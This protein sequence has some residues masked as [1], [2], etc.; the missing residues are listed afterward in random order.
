MT[1]PRPK[2]TTQAATGIPGLDHILGGG[3][4]RHWLYLV[5]GAPGTGKTTLGLQFLLEG[6][7]Q[8]ERV[9]YVTLS[10]TELELRE[11]AGSHGWSMGGVPI[12]EFSAGEA[13]NRLAADQTVLHTA[14]V[15]LGETTDALLEVIMRTR[16]ER[17]VFDPINQIQL[18]TDSPLRYRRQLLTLKQTLTDLTCTSLFLAEEHIPGGYPELQNL[19]HGTLVLEQR[20]PDYGSVR[21]R[22]QLV[23]GRGMVYLGG[24]HSFQIRT[25]GLDVYPRLDTRKRD[26]H[27]RWKPV[28]SGVE[29]L[30]TLLGGGLEEGIACM[31]VGPTGTGKT[32]IA[33]LYAQAAAARGEPSAVFLFDE[34]IETFY[35]RAE[36]LGMDLQAYTEAGVVQVLQVDTGELSPGE[37]AHVVREA[38][39]TGGAKVVVIDSL[40]G[41]LNAMTQEKLLITQMHELLTYLSQRGILTF[42][43]MAQGGVLGEGEI[44]PLDISYLADAVVFLR[45]FESEGRIRR[46]ISVIKKR[47]GAHESTIRELRI[48]ELGVEVGEPLTAF[49]SILTGTPTFEGNRRTLLNPQDE[50]QSDAEPGDGER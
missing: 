34:R 16:P 19:V 45:H 25:G 40:T 1:L 46:A 44:E 11:I 17:L 31:I 39:E 3:L 27:A 13:A 47:H 36:A 42:L 15:E 30:D 26:G 8:G 21:R 24:Y 28:K 5:Q 7:R 48:T 22:L 35:R 12:Y 32:S 18:L 6:V 20:A 4:P 33:T 38:V 23:K 37:F 29:E 2:P 10:H 49:S 14:D 9:L 41:Y 43:I 50:E